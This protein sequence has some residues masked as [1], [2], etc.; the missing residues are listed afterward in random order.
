ME[1]I[2]EK[3]IS[4]HIETIP[5][6]KFQCEIKIYDRSVSGT[7]TYGLLKKKKGDIGDLQYDGD[8][9]FSK[10]DLV[11]E[12]AN[13]KDDKNISPYGMVLTFDQTGKYNFQ[14]KYPNLNFKSLDE[15]EKSISG[16]YPDYIYINITKGLIAELDEFSINQMI[17]I[18][19][20]EA[21]KILQ[22]ESDVE[23][24]QSISNEFY[25]LMLNI[26]A[27]GEIESGRFDHLYSIFSESPSSLIIDIYNSF[28]LLGN[29]SWI[30]IIRESIQLYS[31]FHNNVEE[32]RKE[33]GIESIEKKTES[34]IMDRF[35]K[36]EPTLNSLRKEYIQ[37]NSD[38]FTKVLVGS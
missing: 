30:E 8:A 22:F 1:K 4:D 29:N 32:A 35:Y 31:H 17:P 25:L 37:S 5:E 27:E 38:K 21:R 14:L 3:V 33:L 28:L 26:R 12:L 9:Q 11:D 19:T 18:H 16:F 34:D 7:Y 6:K 23:Y 13:Q 24:T 10:F 36:I 15:V 20:E 2:I